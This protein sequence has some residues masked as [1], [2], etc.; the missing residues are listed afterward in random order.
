[1]DDFIVGYEK[2]KN[3]SQYTIEHLKKTKKSMGNENFNELLLYVDFHLF[4]KSKAIIILWNYKIQSIYSNKNILVNN[5][6]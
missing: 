1:M 4:F 6:Y 3:F 5:I 2:E